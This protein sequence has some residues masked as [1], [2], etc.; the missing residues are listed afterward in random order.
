MAYTSNNSTCDFNPNGTSKRYG[1][2]ELSQ[3]PGGYQVVV[4]FK[5]GDM[6]VSHDRI[7]S[8]LDYGAEIILR[9]NK[10]VDW[11]SIIED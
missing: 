2:S 10:E 7:K 5:D 8:P 6:H 9:Y 11:F 4:R 1:M 3:I